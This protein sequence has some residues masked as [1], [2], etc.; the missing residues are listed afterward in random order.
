MGSGAEAVKLAGAKEVTGVHW[1]QKW[2]R[3][4]S[5]TALGVKAWAARSA[6]SSCSSLWQARTRPPSKRA[7]KAMAHK[8]LVATAITVRRE[9]WEDWV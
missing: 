5:Q 8:E 6:N 4:S 7:G 9:I 2:I 1:G 3:G